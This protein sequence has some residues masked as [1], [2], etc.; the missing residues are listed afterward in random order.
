MKSIPLADLLLGLRK[1]LLEAQER[2]AQEQLRFRVEEIEVEVQV[3]TT[4]VGTVEG[5]V[6]FWVVDAGVDGSIESQKLQT[7]R[8]KL[9]PDDATGRKTLVSDRDSK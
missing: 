2:A 6:K 9:K 4:K 8:L 3:G 5:G 1:E 7:L